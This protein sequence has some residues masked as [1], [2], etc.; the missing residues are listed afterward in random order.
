MTALN[1]TG[2]AE[3][4]YRMAQLANFPE[5]QAREYMDKHGKLRKLSYRKASRGII[6]VSEKTIWQWI[7]EDKFPK[8]TYLSES[9]AVWP[10]SAINNWLQK[11]GVRFEPMPQPV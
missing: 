3:H 5:R 11:K 6:N 10:A 8:P 4:C 7:K 9:V 1:E 2:V